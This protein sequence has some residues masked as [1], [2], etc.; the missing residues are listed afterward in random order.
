MTE[1]PTGDTPTNLT[2]GTLNIRDGRNTRLAIAM[3]CMR[4]MR[5]GLGVLTETKISHDMYPHYAEGYTIVCTK[6]KSR[7]GGV[8]LFFEQ[9]KDFSVEGTR[10]FGANVIRATLVSGRKRWYIIG[11]Y[12]PPSEV[13]GETLDCITQA[14]TTVTNPNLPVVLLGVFNVDLDDLRS[15]EHGA[16]RR[17]ETETLIN[18]MGLK[19]MRQH[20]S[21]N[22]W[23][24]GRHWTWFQ[25]RG[26]K[27]AGAICDH[28]FAST[29][30]DFSSVQIKM[31]RF[32]TDHYMLKGVMALGST[33]DHRRYVNNRRQNPLQVKQSEQSEADARL[34][35]LAK[36]RTPREKSDGMTYSWISPST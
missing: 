30:A 5:V 3:R 25:R 1:K 26:D 31:P 12:I 8:A 34:E 16:V 27:R 22:K 24:V 23:H 32:V 29:R 28:I 6:S 35:E 9:S 17:T 21:Q 15:G 14:S 11:A 36:A 13:N 10:A 19:S 4:E 18:S 33:R 2:I 20:F 7:Q